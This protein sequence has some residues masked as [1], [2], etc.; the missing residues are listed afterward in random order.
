MKKKKKN[1]VYFQSDD[2]YCTFTFQVNKKQNT[3]ILYKQDEKIFEWKNIKIKNEFQLS[4]AAVTGDIQRI[5]N[6]LI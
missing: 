4:I 2:K 1:D 5:F 6:L 3:I